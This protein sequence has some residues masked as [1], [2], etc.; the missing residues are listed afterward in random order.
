MNISVPAVAGQAARVSVADTRPVLFLHI[1]KCAGTSV[2][3]M[4]TNLVGEAHARR[5]HLTTL[6][7][8]QA[9]IAAALDPDD[10]QI[11]FISGHLPY[12]MFAAYEGKFRLFT[13]LRD[14]VA[15]VA[16]L[17]RFLHGQPDLAARGLR[18]DFTFEEFMASPSGAV[19]PGI[20]NAMC[21][22]LSR[23][24]RFHTEAEPEFLTLETHAHVLDEALETLRESVFGLAERM[25]ESCALVRQE[26]GVPFAL[27]AAALNVSSRDAGF[28]EQRVRASILARN[29]LD[30]V[31]YER[32]QAM[33]AQRLAALPRVTPGA[34]PAWVFRPALEVAAPSPD[35][36]GRQGF[37]D[38][39]E[40]LSWIVAHETARLHFL[41][42]A[43][44]CR[45]ILVLYC[46]SP[47]YPV[48]R[49]ALRVN[50]AAIGFTAVRGVDHWVE[51]RSETLTFGD[52]VNALTIMPP[53]VLPVRDYLPQNDDDRQL[54]VALASILFSQDSQMQLPSCLAEVTSLAAA[55][56]RRAGRAEKPTLFRR[57][58]RKA[59]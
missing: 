4:F 25:A 44:A 2:V 34:A 12:F 38:C 22:M 19:F 5:L 52:G 56:A 14:P 1:P 23:E 40:G 45:I 46:L 11:A 29:Q 47:D 51:L 9:D 42:P 37:H 30:L 55:R 53:C 31:L 16:S 59:L 50:G 18:E 15:R 36:A 17:F 33:F 21:R 10:A 27:N 8:T 28:D 58:F 24:T 35:I 49:I 7:T 20:D 48:E 57:I 39:F 32:A 54:S 13:M 6:E 3:S 26:F 41:P 43:P